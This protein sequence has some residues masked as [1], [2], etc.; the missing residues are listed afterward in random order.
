MLSKHN[1]ERLAGLIQAFKEVSVERMGYK[2]ALLYLD[3]LIDRLND[4]ISNLGVPLT[5]N[6]SD[7]RSAQFTT[8]TEAIYKVFYEIIVNA[9]EHGV[10]EKGI[11]LSAEQSDKGLFVHVYDYGEG[12]K[13]EPLN[14]I[15]ESFFTTGRGIQKK[16]G[17]GLFQ[18]QNIVMQLLQGEIKAYNKEGF[19]FEIDV[20]NP[21]TKKQE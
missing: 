2:T 13:D 21:E 3:S 18:V 12:V 9:V 6:L 20:P 19:H 17:L 16:L 4:G 15:F 7:Y 8:F 11:K 1:I 5:V 14:Y 10:T